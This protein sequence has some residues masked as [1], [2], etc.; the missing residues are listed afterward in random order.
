MWV[1]LSVFWLMLGGDEFLEPRLV[2]RTAPI[3]VD[4]GPVLIFWLDHLSRV[5]GA[6]RSNKE[7]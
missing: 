7:G 5:F 1:L 4:G 2:Q 6:K 3:A